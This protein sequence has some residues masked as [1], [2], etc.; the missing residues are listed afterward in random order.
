MGVVV[1]N[2]LPLHTDAIK[3]NLISEEV[4]REQAAMKY[5]EEADVLNVAMFGQMAKQWCEAHHE[6]KGNIRDYVP[7]TNSFA[8]QIWRTSMP[9]S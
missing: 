8:W 5:A 7:S 3:R 1:E 2:Q 4:T 9:F 6:L